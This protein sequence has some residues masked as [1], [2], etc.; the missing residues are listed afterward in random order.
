MKRHALLY[1]SKWSKSKNR[2]P[3]ILR[4]ARQVGKSW[5]VKEL[6]KQLF[7][8]KLDPK[9]LCEQLAIYAQQTITPGETLMFF[10]EVQECPQ[11]IKA[12]VKDYFWLGGMPAVI[13][14]WLETKDY[15]QC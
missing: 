1:L 15:K 10:D 4:G 14:C 9:I 5:L 2:K 6:A 13:D 7:S 3:L 12:L 8:G 11:A